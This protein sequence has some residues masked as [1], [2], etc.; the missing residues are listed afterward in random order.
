MYVILDMGYNF[1][2]YLV[3]VSIGVEFLVI[4]DREFKGDVF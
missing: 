2:C 3:I 1:D 4:K